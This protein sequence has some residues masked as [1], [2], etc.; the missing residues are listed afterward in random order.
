MPGGVTVRIDYKP[1]CRGAALHQLLVVITDITDELGRES[2]EATQRDLVRIV[3]G[4]THDRRGLLEFFEESD[5]L[6]ERIVG[7]T[8]ETRPRESLARDLHTMKGNC[9]LFGLST[10]AHLCHRLEERMQDG[11]EHLDQRSRS[12][13]RSCWAGFQEKLRFIS[14]RGSAPTVDVPVDGYQL[15]LRALEGHPELAE[16]AAV[17]RSW[18]MEPTELRLQRAAEQARQLAARLGKGEILTVIEAN[19]LRLPPETWATFWSA[20]AHVVRN[21]TDH[22]L[23]DQQVRAAAGKPGRGRLSFRTLLRD[24]MFVIELE[25]DGRGIDWAAVAVRAA[26]R[27]IRHQTES[28]LMEALFCAGVSTKL[29][30][31][32]VSGRGVGLEAVRT[33]CERLG[34][35]VVVTSTLGR[36]TVFRFTWPQE[37]VKV[38]K[39]PGSEP[40]SGV[41]DAP[42]SL[43]PSRPLSSSTLR[44]V[45][46]PS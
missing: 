35:Q 10:V 27:G 44:A 16:W 39:G 3:E 19:G 14:G 18:Q 36:G 42:A 38:E 20:F 9:G 40:V 15:I 23:E 43:P 30:V 8:S 46:A 13:L 4:L 41:V 26:K 12:E 28:E 7:P 21:A 37:A 5:R 1:I 22:G 24:E 25:D 2:A 29:A 11:Q 6:I 32:D 17:A 45:R 33:E 34:G 31:T